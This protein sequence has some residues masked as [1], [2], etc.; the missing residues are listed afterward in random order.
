MKHIALTSLFLLV[1]V[2]SQAQTYTID[3]FN[4]GTLTTCS[5]TLYDSGGPNGNYQAGET[6]TITI[7]PSTPGAGIRLEFTQFNLPNGSLCVYDGP[8]LA[9]NQ[10]GCFDNGLTLTNVGASGAN[11]SGCITLTF[12]SSGSGPGWAAIIT[13]VT[14]CQVVNPEIVGVLTGP[15]VFTPPLPAYVDICPDENVQVAAQGLYP[16]NGTFYQQDDAT[17]IFAWTFGN[18]VQDSGQFSGV[19]YSDPGGYVILLEVTDVNGCQNTTFPSQKIRVAPDPQYFRSSIQDTICL[20]DTATLV[21]DAVTPMVDFSPPSFFSEQLPLPDNVGIPYTTSIPVQGYSGFATVATPSDL[22][23]ICVTMEHSF[24]GDLDITITC[25]TG[26]TIDLLNYPSGGGG[27]FLG[28]PNDFDD[29]PNPQVV[30]VGYNYCWEENAPAGTWGD[31]AN[32]FFQTFTDVSGNVYNNQAYLPA[33][34]YAPEQSFAGLVGCPVNGIWTITITDNLGIDNGF[35]FNWGLT[36]NPNYLDPIY[37]DSFSTVI[38]DSL[39]L[40]APGIVANNGDVLTVS[41]ATPGLHTYTYQ[42]TDDFGCVHDTSF[43][44]TVLAP[45]NLLCLTCDSI[46]LA[47]AQSTDTLCLGQTVQLNAD[48][49]SPIAPPAPVCD[50]YVVT[51]TA[52]APVAGSQTNVT[53]T[54]DQLTGALPIGFN[55][56]FFCNN[57]SQFHISSNG[58]IS[59]DPL[60]GAGCCAGQNLPDFFPSNNLIAAAWDDLNP[61]GG[62]TI[63][64][65]TTGAAP[66]RRLVVNWNSVPIFG[67]AGQTVTSQIVLYESTNIAEVHVTSV[68]NISPGTIGIENATGT[69]GYAAPGRNAATW[70]ANNEA[71][72]FAP[73]LGNPF[74]NA[75]YTWTPANTLNNAASPAPVGS[76]QA[77][78]DYVVQA[79]W[80]NCVFRDTLPVAVL[81]LPAPVLSCGT[82]TTSSVTFEWAPIA[83]AVYY[84]VS[85]NG[86]ATWINVGNV[87]AYVVNNLAPGQTFT[88]QVRAFG[89]CPGPSATLSC[90]SENCTIPATTLSC[91][92]ASGSSVTF[93]WVAV[94][95]A[96]SYEIS[97]DGGATWTNLGNVLTYTANGLTP[98]Q[99]VTLQ[100]RPVGAQCTGAA[101][102]LSCTATCALTASAVQSGIGCAGSDS[103]DLALDFAGNAG[104]VAFLWSNGSTA[105]DLV[106]LAP[107][108]YTVTVTD[109]SACTAT[110]A[111]TVTEVPIPVLD[112]WAGAPGQVSDTV[113]GGVPVELNAGA[114]E[115]GVTYTWSPAANLNTATGNS[116]TGNF[117]QPGQYV[118]TVTAANIACTNSDEVSV[119][120][121]PSAFALPNAFTP[122]GDPLNPVFRPLVSGNATIETFKVYDRWG[123]LVFDDPLSGWDGTRNGEP[124][125]RDVYI[126]VLRIRLPDDAETRTV[127]GDVTLIR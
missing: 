40:N 72:R 36:F 13:C 99:T 4:N 8:N 59:F 127:T 38:V 64:Y 114:N 118:F 69:A 68:N 107:G 27:T 37:Q 90:T 14:P 103:G 11:N 96:I 53:L 52:F 75:V 39:W 12:T 123:N 91:G 6:Y 20:G 30:G 125:P 43:T 106:D 55:F 21:G 95:G 65:F 3:Q 112:A 23:S 66:N 104:A 22:Q 16:Q 108:S 97:L 122:N 88:I 15:D 58:F 74:A 56:N 44:I 80:N 73:D 92:T 42:V 2:L 46:F 116:V 62:G 10:Y 110:A 50:E 82:P 5:G 124:M 67:G 85:L 81:S 78:L 121:V 33:G 105:E 9:A 49:F 57:Y 71:W 93:D 70:S 101:V 25:P 29:N 115:A 7:C 126:Y 76:P 47:T 60:A 89:E 51:S 86:G 31:N 63:G 102:S 41:P 77:T 54:D 119:V 45:G 83:G 17:S 117:G 120:V 48:V 18:G 61:G 109:A 19:T 79:T 35:I 111:A 1:T 113:F 98:T 84:E 87:L 32:T 24:M 100:V 94:A 26:Q 28:E 34:D